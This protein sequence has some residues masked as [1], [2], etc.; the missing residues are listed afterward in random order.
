MYNVRLLVLLVFIGCALRATGQGPDKPEKAQEPTDAQLR[1]L[2]AQFQDDPLGKD[3]KELAKALLA[4]AAVT[5]RAAVVLGEEEMAWVGDHERYK[6]L[7]LAGYLGGNLQ[8]QFNSGIKQN[9]RYAGLLTLFQ[10][11]RAIREQDKDYK[12]PELDKLLA[13]Q[14]EGKLLK[15]IVELEARKPSRLSPEDEEAIKKIRRKDR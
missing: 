13:L 7:L 10:V 12:S 2:F 15:H 4:V 8:S 1:R 6:F 3:G 14:K 5:S 9:D 11:Y